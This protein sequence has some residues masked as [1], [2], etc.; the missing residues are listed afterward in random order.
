MAIAKTFKIFTF[1]CKTNQIESDFIVQKLLKNG[2]TKLENTESTEFTVINSCSVT[3]KADDEI[4]YLIRKTKKHEP[5][6]KVVL[7]GCLAQTDK[8]NLANNPDIFAI[9]G[10]SEKLDIVNVLNQNR[11]DVF[12]QDIMLQEHFIETEPVLTSKT[13]A[14]IKIQD[15]CNNYCS[16]CIVPFA[17]GKSRSCREQTILNN[18]RTLTD[19]GYKEIILSGI[20]FGQWGK[21]FIPQ[22]NIVD[23]LEKLEVMEGLHRYRLGSVDP[24]E[25][26]E[27]MLDFLVKAKK[28]CSHLHLSLQSAND[29]TLQAMNRK[30]TVEEV[31][32]KL[33]FLK[34]NIPALNIGADVIVGFPGETDEDFELTCQNIKDMPISY[35]HIFTY[36]KR[37]YTKAAQMPCQI[38][39]TVKKQRAKR[40]KGIA[41]DKKL[42]FLKSLKGM[43]LEVL[44]EKKKHGNLYKATSSNYL[45]FL[46]ESDKDISNNI[47]NVNANTIVN[48]N[49]FAKI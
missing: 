21:D 11:R 43:P 7:C 41:L 16:Y 26:D 14:V 23:L 45:Q 30:Y 3:S 47:I 6:T 13:R 34:Q 44:V 31:K 5:H 27:R 46:I 39:E 19:K 15:G 2:Y 20:H 37:K 10:N 48:G 4:L 32:Q 18:I 40:L 49:L 36:S 9:A 8:D 42:N 35:M 33:D 17:R 24:T 22:E 25:L 38:D 29:K 1:G 28:N 12:V